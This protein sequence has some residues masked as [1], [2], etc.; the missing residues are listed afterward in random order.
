MDGERLHIDYML[1]SGKAAAGKTF[2]YHCIDTEEKDE[3]VL[4]WETTSGVKFRCVKF[5]VRGP[6]VIQWIVSQIGPR[7]PGMC[8]MGRMGM[9]D[10]PMVYYD[11]I[12]GMDLSGDSKPNPKC[13]LSGGYVV[14]QWYNENGDEGCEE[15]SIPPLKIENACEEGEG[16]YFL[17]G[18]KTCLSPHEKILIGRQYQCIASWTFDKYTFMMIEQSQP[19]GLLPCLRFTT[20]HGQRFTMHVFLDGVCDSS[21]S[22]SHSRVY[23]QMVLA[24]FPAIGI[25]SDDT[26]ACAVKDTSKCGHLM[27]KSCRQSCRSCA[28]DA[29]WLELTFPEQFHGVWLKDSDHLGRENVT[30]DKL[31]ITIPSLG[32]YRTMGETDCSRRK[33]VRAPYGLTSEAKEYSLVQTFM[34]GCSHRMSVLQIVNRSDSVL[35]FRVS[36]PGVVDWHL[37]V[38]E[39][40][41]L[42]QIMS[43]WEKW[44]DKVTYEQPQVTPTASARTELTGWFNLVQE[45]ADAVTVNCSLPEKIPEQFTM[46]LPSGQQ[47]NGVITQD[48]AD[49]LQVSYKDCKSSGALPSGGSHAIEQL[50]KF[51]CLA[52]FLGDSGRTFLVTRTPKEF[53]NAVNETHICWVFSTGQ[54]LGNVYWFRVSDCDGTSDVYAQRG[55]RQELAR[56]DFHVEPPPANEVLVASAERVAPWVAVHVMALALVI[57]TIR[58]ILG[59]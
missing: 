59:P 37:V 25:C 52:A 58:R 57:P 24:M 30:I 39:V 28:S 36:K 14:R 17:G 23:R 44:C 13:P 10:S 12:G 8:D 51:E 15:D 34:N 56:F 7:R 50:A 41:F 2:T 31:H 49:S 9:Q 4:M 54:S 38:N 11:E 22:I 16:L 19:N 53:P 43:G 32:T 33:P 18:S 26:P 6:N 20:G 3:Y 1:E 29:S 47:C 55:F 27:A 35:S 5:L 42:W 48:G 46:H 21:D 45:D 40:S